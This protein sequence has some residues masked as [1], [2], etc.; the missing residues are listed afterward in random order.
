VK[1]KKG[2][3]KRVKLET[4]FWMG[5]IDEMFTTEYFLDES[6]CT[7]GFREGDPGAHG[8][9]E[10]WDIRRYSNVEP[11]AYENFCLD[12][13]QRYGEYVGVQLEPEWGKGRGYTAPHIHFQ[14][15]AQ[16]RWK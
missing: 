5:K 14:I 11:G 10:A 13:Q 8:R 3:D 4:A 6:T 12:V 15:K 7:S 9:G 2:V 16:A 1:W